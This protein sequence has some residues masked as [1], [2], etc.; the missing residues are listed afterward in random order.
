MS[1]E[2]TEKH[3]PK[4]LS[5]VMGNENAIRIM[6]RWADLWK[7]GTPRKKALT[8]KGAPGTGKTSSA[9]ALAND[10]GWDVIEMNASDH[11]NAASIMRVAGIGSI[12]QT[13]SE[14]GEFLTTAE[15]RRKL[16]ILDE[17]DNLFGREDYGGAK[18]IVETIR[19]TSQP[20]ILIVNDYYALTRKASAV[21]TLAEKVKFRSLNDRAVIAVLADICAKEGVEVGDTVLG[22]IARNAAG[23]MRG[24]INDLQMMVEGRT[25]IDEKD[26]DVLSERNQEMELE[27]ALNLMFGARSAKE[28]RNATLDIDKT[29]EEFIL[30]VEE[31]IPKEFIIPA[32]MAAAFDALS[33]SDIFLKRTKVLRHYGLWSY[34]KEMM[35]A[36]VS[37][38]RQ[39][40][41][42]S[43]PS[44]YGFPSYLIVMSRSRSIRK[45]RAE[46]CSKLSPLL[47]AS[48]RS[49]G[50]SFLPFLSKMA[51]RDPSLLA[52]LGAEAG[53]DEGDVAFLLGVDPGSDEVSDAMDLIRLTRSGDAQAGEEGIAK[54]GT[55]HKR[56]LS[57]F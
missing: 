17:A 29:P 16:I 36:G 13:F 33:R 10:Y 26:A 52:D 32:E 41:R 27:T 28:A 6:K 15:G 31:S 40:T 2:W 5:Q 51:K 48:A 9:I 14:G 8:L 39:G 18:A 46:L 19:H 50:S 11:R 45:S 22:M 44:R 43:P 23:D 57:D 3:R 24:A 4:S 21:K 12:S 20:I 30:W 35:T 42:R 34:A 1:E 38:A 55:R 7:S 53:L 54:R 25:R 56:S 37:L 47:H 49:I